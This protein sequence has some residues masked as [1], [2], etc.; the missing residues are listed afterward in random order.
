MKNI[1]TV[2]IL[3]MLAACVNNSTD[4][5]IV[6]DTAA[7]NSITNA[8]INVPF[9]EAKNYFVKNT[10]KADSSTNIKIVTQ[11]DFD[12]I[13]GMASTMNQDSK[14]T[15]IDFSKQ[16]VIAVIQPVTDKATSLRVESLVRKENNIVLNYSKN[17]GGKQSFTTRPF[18]LLIVDT[19]Y[20]G[21]LAVQQQ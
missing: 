14:P 5:N 21:S 13:F 3:S 11:Q 16:Y 17:E 9:T 10:F 19:I 2:I 1:F 15:A 18:L 6:N 4:T 8:A 20:T 12:A 7:V